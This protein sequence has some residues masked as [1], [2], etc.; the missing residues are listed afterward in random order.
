MYSDQV[1][2]A[3]FLAIMGGFIFVFLA[4]GVVFYVLKS[5]GL[6]NMAVNRNMEN[7]W[8]AWIPIGDLYILGSLVGEMEIFGYKLTNL[9]IVTLAVMIGGM[10]LSMIPFLGL[11]FSLA[12]AVYAIF[13]IYNLFQNYSPNNAVLY[14]I[15]SIILGLFP[16]FIFIVRNNNPVNSELAPPSA[17]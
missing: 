8:L 10:I 4:I 12:V 3:S 17:F 15:L 9:G 5:L 1:A 11:I 6:Y 16:I 2:A 14:T 7:P 13:L